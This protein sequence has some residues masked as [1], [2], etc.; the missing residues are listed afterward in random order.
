MTDCGFGSA[1][2]PSMQVFFHGSFLLFFLLLS[3][4]VFQKKLI[5][6]GLKRVLKK[7]KQM[8]FSFFFPCLFILLKEMKTKM[9]TRLS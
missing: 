5:K 7:I 6:Q 9:K 4:S 3:A 8:F 1:S 2:V